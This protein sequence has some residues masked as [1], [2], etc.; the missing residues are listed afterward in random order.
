MNIQYVAGF[1][2]DESR[3]IVALIRKN[4]PQWQRGK[5]NGIGG[6]IDPG[7]TPLEAMVREFREETGCETRHFAWSHFLTMN[8]TDGAE[9]GEWSVHFFTAAGDLSLVNTVEDEV[10]E[11]VL[12]ETVTPLRADMIENLSWLIPLALDHFNDARPSF[13]VATYSE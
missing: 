2:F 6:K 3:T 7:E 13:V 9:N 5:L 4:K 10:V 11:K 1:L 8:G 12:I